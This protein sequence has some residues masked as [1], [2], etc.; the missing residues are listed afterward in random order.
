MIP[1]KP[2][3]F[4]DPEDDAPIVRAEKSTRQP[5]SPGAPMSIAELYQLCN[6][7]S[8]TMLVPIA[9]AGKESFLKNSKIQ[10]NLLVVIAFFL[11]F[12][13]KNAAFH[14]WMFVQVTD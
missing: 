1:L 14:T 3:N 6:Q 12:L 10:R 9:E 4:Q 5:S 7:I 13:K 11:H 2:W 8:K